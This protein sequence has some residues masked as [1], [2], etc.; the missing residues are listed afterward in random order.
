MVECVAELFR[1]IIKVSAAEHRCSPV[2]RSSRATLVRG[3]P[4]MKRCQRSRLGMPESVYSCCSA[5][6]MFP[7]FACAAGGHIDP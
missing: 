7:L 5:F 1:S 3:W 4:S 6:Y 2:S